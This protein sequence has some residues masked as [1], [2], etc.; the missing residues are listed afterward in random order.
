LSEQS[1]EARFFSKDNEHTFRLN[2]QAAARMCKLSLK[3]E[4]KGVFA[5]YLFAVKMRSKN[6]KLYFYL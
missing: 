6:N 1:D 4:R 5:V 3:K 2:L